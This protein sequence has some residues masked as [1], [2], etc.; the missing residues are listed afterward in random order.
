DA[1][2]ASSSDYSRGLLQGSYNARLSVA[3]VDVTDGHEDDFHALS[4][5][6]AALLLTKGYGRLEMVRDEAQ[7]LRFY[8]V[9]HWID[10]TAAEKC[11]ADPAVQG[12]TARLFKIARVT[13]VVNGV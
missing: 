2:A 6:F 3:L 1:S 8:A 7:P 10:A 13:H 5:E 4:R 9:R 12:W 11:H